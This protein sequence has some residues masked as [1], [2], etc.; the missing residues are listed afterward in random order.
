MAQRAEEQMIQ[1]EAK[2]E[3]LGL[4]HLTVNK[5]FEM[6]GYAKHV[7]NLTAHD[8]HL[9]RKAIAIASELLSTAESAI[10]CINANMVPV[11]AQRVHEQDNTCVA[12]ACY[13][14]EVL[15]TVTGAR[16]AAEAQRERVAPI[17]LHLQRA[18]SHVHV[19]E[20]ACSA[21][22][23]L[24]VHDSTAQD[25]VCSDD[26]MHALYLL[27]DATTADVSVT[28]ACMRLEIVR[29]CMA[30]NNPGLDEKLVQT[31]AIEQILPLL[32]A[33]NKH[34]VKAA[35][36][37]LGLLCV[38]FSGKKSAEDAGSVAR[39]LTVLQ[40][41]EDDPTLQTNATAALMTQCI[42]IDSKVTLHKQRGEAIIAKVLRTTESEWLILALIQLVSALAEYPQSK[43]ALA[44]TVRTQLEQLRMHL[45]VGIARHAGFA[46]RSLDFSHLHSEWSGA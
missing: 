19:R 42:H 34:I 40:D 18:H 41:H 30:S 38:P 23:E 6:H 31:G 22:L 1:H 12:N 37:L 8:I 5:G 28:M 14:L 17:L 9:R 16:G 21:L 45:N 35:T 43:D 24:V 33:T 3:I 44:Q 32:G 46:C 2:E 4:G 39:L 20:H 11:L 29:V 27:R 25:D 13:A 36:R 7:R 15:A 26:A 10:A